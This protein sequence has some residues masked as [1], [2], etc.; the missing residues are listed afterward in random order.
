MTPAEKENAQMLLDQMKATT[1]EP[2]PLAPIATAYRSREY[3]RRAQR[4][5]N[6]LKRFLEDG[7]FL[8]SY[9]DSGYMKEVRRLREKYPEEERPGLVKLVAFY[10]HQREKYLFFFGSSESEAEEMDQVNP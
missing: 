2:N 7:N 9:S 8:D 4:K 5:M 1:L 3:R 10:N 6:M